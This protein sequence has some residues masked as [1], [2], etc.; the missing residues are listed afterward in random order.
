MLFSN[1]K[2]LN[3]FFILLVTH[4]ITTPTHAFSPHTYVSLSVIYFSHSTHLNTPPCF[5]L[6]SWELHFPDLCHIYQFISIFYL[7]SLSLPPSEPKH[8]SALHFHPSC[9]CSHHRWIMSA[10]KENNASQNTSHRLKS[11]PALFLQTRRLE[12]QS[13]PTQRVHYGTLLSQLMSLH[14]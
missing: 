7:P 4:L 14:T 5:H 11:Q 9:W 8:I 12:A 3:L 6:C 10:I 13:R 2:H 1:V